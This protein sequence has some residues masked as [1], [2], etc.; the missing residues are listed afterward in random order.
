MKH[1]VWLKVMFV[2]LG[3]LFVAL[4]LLPFALSAADIAAPLRWDVN[5]SE[6]SAHNEV[7]TRQE[8][9]I[10]E[11]RFMLGTSP[12]D[13]SAVYTVELAMRRIGATNWVRAAT[14]SVSSVAG[15]VSIPY[16]VTA[17]TGRYDYAVIV[18]D[19]DE[20]LCR[21][22]GQFLVRPGAY[23]NGA[24]D[25][26]TVVVTDFDWDKVNHINLGR[27]PFM[28]TYDVSR[29][30]AFDESVRSWWSTNTYLHGTNDPAF[31]AYVQHAVDAVTIQGVVT[32][33]QP[34]VTFGGMSIGSITLGGVQRSSWPSGGGGGGGGGI[35][36]YTNTEINGLSNTNAIRIGDGDHVLWMLGTDGVWRAS[37]TNLATATQGA[38]GD[39]AFAHIGDT[40][41]PHHVT[42]EQIGAITNIPQ[43][44]SSTGAVYWIVDGIT[45]GR[46]DSNG[47]TMIKGSLQL[48]EEDLRCNVRLNDG[49]KNSPS[50]TPQGHANTI[51]MYVRGYSGSY[52][53]GFAHASQ[54]VAV[55]HKYGIS[56]LSTNMTYSGSARGLT[57]VPE[58]KFD[59]FAT[60]PA[61]PGLTIT[62]SGLVT[63]KDAGGTTRFS[64]NGQTGATLIRGQDSDARYQQWDTNAWFSGIRTTYTH[65]AA[66]TT[67][68][69][70]IM[71]YTNGHLVGWTQL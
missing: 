43:N 31:A 11:P 22:A 18:T 48:Q 15:R 46:V 49:T 65:N 38:H 7:L 70:N 30:E 33:T 5:V 63:V 54:D 68:V 36:S 69:T 44:W 14:G 50:L 53:F 3:A 51:G 39:A 57:D 66:G 26:Q 8:S 1:A 24:P 40:S 37:A 59:G 27:A 47:I 58:L 45:V 42:C 61:L 60:N 13:L 32:N 29:L 28:V 23:D 17:T 19:S 52:G 25:T 20:M 34:Y 4:L 9:V 41:N 62:N 10:V 21:A 2:T 35:G 71:T 56:L 64:V 6:S 16:Q 67:I 55:I 12:M